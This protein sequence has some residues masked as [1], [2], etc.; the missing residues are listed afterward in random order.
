MGALDI[1]EKLHCIL[2]TMK[3]KELTFNFESL[4][5]TDI[6]QRTTIV[7]CFTNILLQI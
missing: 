4:T 6:G 7:L 2:I 5:C 3:E 1:T